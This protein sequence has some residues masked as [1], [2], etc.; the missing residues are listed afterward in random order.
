[1]AS[2]LSSYV[3]NVIMGAMM[4][5]AFPGIFKK[6][7]AAKTAQDWRQI[8][9]LCDLHSAGFIGISLVGLV[10]LWLAGPHL[11]G[12]LIGRKYESSLG[13]LLPAG[14]AAITLQCNQF[15]FLLLQGQGN[16]SAMAR[17][18]TWVALVKTS[19]TVLSLMI[20]WQAFEVWLC[21]SMPV[22]ALLGRQL[23]RSAAFG[24][25]RLEK[26]D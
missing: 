21:I 19:G 17:V 15:Q 16:S 6:S 12:W 25:L 20:S 22:C 13:M 4:Q 2:A 1:M 23:I 9:R 11:S 3:P 7:D 10:V 8:E 18:L 26:K 5:F 14:I 24:E